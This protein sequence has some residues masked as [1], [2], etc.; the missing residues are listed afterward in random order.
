LRTCILVNSSVQRN[1]SEI[2]R[3]NLPVFS[4][5]NLGERLDFE[6]DIVTF[7]HSIKEKI[8]TSV[9]KKVLGWGDRKI[10]G[11]SIN[12]LLS[13]C[14][15]NLWQYQRFR[16]YFTVRYIEYELQA[17]REIK[18]LGYDKVLLLS[19]YNYQR[20][21][22]IEGLQISLLKINKERKPNRKI[23]LV[24][25]TIVFVIR[26]IIGFI[27]YFV[28]KNNKTIFLDSSIKQ[29]LIYA[30]GKMVMDNYNLGYL[31]DKLGNNALVLDEILVPTV[32]QEF[33]LKKSYFINLFKSRKILFAEYILLKGLLNPKNYH[34]KKE[35]FSKIKIQYKYI[36]DN[37][38]TPL[39]RLIIQTLRSIHLSNNYYL[40]RFLAYKR[41]FSNK[42]ISAVLATDENGPIS[43]SFLDA[44]KYNNI[45]TIGIQHG[46]IH[47]LHPN[48]Y[49]TK[50]ESKYIPDYTLIWG[51]KWEELLIGYGNYPPS[52]LRVVGQLRTDIIPILKRKEKQNNKFIVVFAS[53]PQRDSVLRKQTAQDIFTAVKDLPNVHLVVKL[54]PQEKNDVGYYHEIAKNVGL[55]RISI[56]PQSELYQTILESD[57]VIT[58]FSTVGTEAIYFG[59]ILLIYDPLNQDLQKYIKGKVAFRVQNSTDIINIVQQVKDKKLASNILQYQKFID[60]NAYK[61]DGEVANRVLNFIDSI[62]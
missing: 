20:D 2:S 41:F 61:I 7:S 18:L 60:Y 28:V 15:Y 59:K 42:K 17:L 57:I 22:L 44:A 48:Y 26:A 3:L 9:F 10:A 51:R 55:S 23:A 50:N 52:K 14:S 49:F 39:D 6:Y 43:R 29:P 1:S 62:E 24:N 8:N 56:L 25:Y 19:D 37:L 31:F 30:D 16:V 12:D 36:E 33:L 54:H 40:F 5:I 46:A 45:R 27:Q 58:S 53:Q 4:T 13:I 21:G 35:I 11:K 32:G 34:K 38:N 47:Q